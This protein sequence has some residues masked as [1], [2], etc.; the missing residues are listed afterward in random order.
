MSV[1][2]R[3]YQPGDEKAIISLWNQCLHF[4]PISV[5]RF[6][7]LILLDANFSSE[8]MILAFDQQRLVGAIYGIIRK[9]PLNRDDLELDNGWISFFFVHSNYEKQGIG[10]ELMQ[11]VSNFFKTHHRKN[12]FF[13]SYA[14]NYILP[15]IDAS[16]YPSGNQFLV[17][18]GFQKQYTA[19]AMDFSLLD[20]HYP[21]G[22]QDLTLKREEEG[23]HIRQ[24]TDS[25]LIEL[26]EFANESFNPDW[27]RAIREGLINGMPMK[28]I[29]IARNPKSKL[30]GFGLYGAYEGVNERFGPFGVDPEERGKGLGKIILNLCLNQMKAEGYHNAWFLW[31]G[32]KTTAGYLYLQTGFKVTRRFDVVKKEIVSHD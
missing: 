4:D 30:V 16:A 6:R 17:Q 14:P 1:T 20:Y 9:I 18:Q 23:Y 8:G 15:G 11:R 31:T 22:I 3:C 13:S 28:N 27:G 7:H 32:E 12:V 5:E 29:V 21:Q 10:S 25:D 24:A 2:F 19:A 26:I